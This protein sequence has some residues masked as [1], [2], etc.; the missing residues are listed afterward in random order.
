M[1]STLPESRATIVRRLR[2][3]RALIGSWALSVP[4]LQRAARQAPAPSARLGQELG[5]IATA[6][7]VLGQ[8]ALAILARATSA[9]LG[10]LQQAPALI[11]TDASGALDRAVPALLLA[12]EV[13]LPPGAA[14]SL[15][16]VYRSVQTLVGVGRVHPADLW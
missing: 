14:V 6:L 16:P 1:A 15:F 10:R 4:R 9:A 11:H 5:E 2:S 7:E 3:L 13:G 12:T 8:P